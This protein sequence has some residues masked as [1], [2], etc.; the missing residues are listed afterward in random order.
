MIRASLRPVIALALL[1]GAC[2]PKAT[3]LVGAAVEPARLPP[4]RLA[5]RHQLLAFTWAYED[6][7]M[8]ASG[9]G[10]ARVAPPDSARLDLFLSGG[11]GGGQALVLADSLILPASGG[12]PKRFLPPVAMFWAALGRLAVPAGDTTVRVD[13]A[14]TRADI[15][16]GGEVMRVAFDGERLASLERVVDGGIQERLVRQGTRMTYEHLGA[17]RR[18]TLVITRTT[19]DQSFDASIW[20]H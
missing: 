11:L 1:A 16:R 20:R 8:R 7:D 13:G 18:L 10:A 5:S 6:A 12:I 9:E 3:S 19:D 2:V 15:A 14:V 4:G 17:R